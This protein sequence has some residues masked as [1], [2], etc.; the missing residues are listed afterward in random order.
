[1]KTLK[2]LSTTFIAVLF[3]VLMC[4]TNLL[5]Q[6]T[7][8]MDGKNG[9]ELFYCSSVAVDTNATVTSNWFTAPAY[10]GQNLFTYKVSYTK[11]QTSTLGKPFITTI[12]EGSN[13]QSNV[14]TVDTVGTLS[15]SL[16]T[17]YT[18]TMSLDKDT[19]YVKYLFYRFKFIGEEGN[20][21]DAVV[22]YVSLLF[23][24]P[25]N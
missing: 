21:S 25:T 16:E 3:A 11:K 9:A 20:R 13:D 1:M 22:N 15:D 17:L 10:I 12:I 14:V 23:T 2:I 24:K 8:S 18:G 4:G 19:T 5:A 7:V 6:E